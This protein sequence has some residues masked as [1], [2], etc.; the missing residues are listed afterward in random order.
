MTLFEIILLAA[1]FYFLLRPFYLGY[2]YSRPSRIKVSF[3]TPTSLGVSYEDV[4]L[5]TQDG[6]DLVGWYIPSHNGA[7]VYLIHGHGG[8]RLGG[9]FHAEA[10]IRAGYGVLMLDL[11]AHGDS[12][13]RRFGRSTVFVDDVLTAVAFLRKRPDVTDAG[14]GL[15]GISVGGMFALHAAAQTVAVRALIVDGISPAAIADLPQANNLLQKWMGW[16][17]Q[18]F[19]MHIAA[20]FANLP[21]LPA[22]T[23][24]A[25]RIAPRPI[26]FISTGQGAEKRMGQMLYELAGEPKQHWLLPEARHASGWHARPDEYG[27]KIVHFFN[28]YLRLD[29]QSPLIPE[30]MSTLAESPPALEKN[31]DREDVTLS[32][33]KANGLALLMI[34]IAIG[35]FILPYYFFWGEIA[36]DKLAQLD[37]INWILLLL[38][39]LGSTFVHEALHAVGYTAVGG[40]AWSDVQ[41][42]FSWQGLAPYA[43]CRVGMSASAY[44][45]AVILPALILGILPGL[46]GL[47]IGSWWLVVYAVMMLIAA[48]GDVAILII[49]RHIAGHRIVYDHPSEVGCQVQK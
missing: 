38:L 12:D 43:H 1:I 41:F 7:A 22:N 33:G 35:L 31:S 3:F 24:V 30:R 17:M 19:F 27:Q 20:W 13:G 42:G 11:R 23:S 15:L 14:I 32:F 47:I 4:R 34:P 45:T 25:G 40:A 5:T 48:G 10:L 6:V 28:Q 49:M 18:R 8:N 29:M 39:F 21:P 46:L 16:P 37:T 9:V 36:F 26:L 2:S 44:R